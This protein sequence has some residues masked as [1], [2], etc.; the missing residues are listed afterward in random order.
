MDTVVQP[1]V[2]VVCDEKKLDDRGVRGAPDW[3]VDVLSPATA[4]HDQIRKLAACERAGVPEIWLVQPADRVLT[5][6][7]LE[8]DHY[9]RRSLA[10]DHA[11]CFGNLD[12]RV[13][14]R[15]K[16]D[17]VGRHAVTKNHAGFRHRR[18]HF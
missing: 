8:A 13:Q 18:Y 5:I 17:R 11:F 3:V 6:Y 9:G 7:V 1:D 16:L 10:H 15:M 2:L 14:P 4:G 12:R